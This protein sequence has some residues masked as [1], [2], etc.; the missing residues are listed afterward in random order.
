MGAVALG[1]VFAVQPAGLEGEVLADLDDQQLVAVAGAFDLDF[2]IALFQGNGFDLHVVIAHPAVGAGGVGFVALDAELDF[3]VQLAEFAPDL[4]VAAGLVGVAGGGLD[5][6]LE[7]HGEL[8]VYLGVFL[9]GML[10]VQL[11]VDPVPADPFAV[12]I[13]AVTVVHGAAGYGAVLQGVS[14]PCVLANSVPWEPG[15]GFGAAGGCSSV[16]CA[17]AVHRAVWSPLESG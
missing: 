16:W 3:G 7:E 12:V 9:F 8:R 15:L 10:F 14:L 11:A 4:Q 6:V 13:D 17:T 2:V 1:P 5:R